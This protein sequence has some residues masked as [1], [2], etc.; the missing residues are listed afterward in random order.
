MLPVELSEQIVPGRFDFALDYLVEHEL[1][2][3]AMDAAPPVPQQAP[4]AVE[5][6]WA[7]ECQHAVAPVLYGAQ[8]R[9]AGQQWVEAMTQM[10]R[11]KAPCNRYRRALG[12]NS[13]CDQGTFTRDAA[14]MSLNSQD[15]MIITKPEIPIVC[16]GAVA[17][18]GVFGQ[19]R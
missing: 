3:S 7:R 15:S 8:H 14:M 19:P 12:Q 4:G 16:C 2:F 18:N 1:D 10:P 17:R 9:E 13:S 5:P 6:A 11:E